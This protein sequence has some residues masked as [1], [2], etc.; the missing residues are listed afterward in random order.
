MR[1]SASRNATD[2]TRGSGSIGSGV[3][4]RRQVLTDVVV[5]LGFA[6]CVVVGTVTVQVLQAG[7]VRDV[8]AVAVVLIVLAALLAVGLRR[9]EPVWGLAGAVAVVG[10]YLLAGYPYGP[11]QLCMV[12]AM[13][14]VARQRPLRLSAIA[15]GVATVVASGTVAVRLLAGDVQSPALV[16]LAWTGWIVLP[17]SLGA[18][19]QMVAAARERARRELVATAAA[20]ERTRLAGE[21][22]DVAGHGFAVVAMQ[23]G[24]ALQ[25]FDESPDQVRRSLEAIRTTSAGSLAELRGMLDAFEQDTRG[26]AAVGTLVGEVRAAGLE[27][28]LELDIGGVTVPRQ[29][30]AVAFRVVQEALTNVV[31][32]AGVARAEVAIGHN[33]D[34]LVVRVVDRGSAV[35]APPGRGLSGMRERIEALGGRLEA[36]PRDGGGFAVLAHLP[37]GSPR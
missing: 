13:F 36:G 37:L 17:W 1:R 5:A 7:R 27:V 10:G 33:G 16:V 32:H 18:L 9:A 8:D 29:V 6:A 15:C 25:V 26:L 3:A 12:I 24:I 35:A 22:H 19:V 20:Q 30:D 4:S 2:Q 28:G 14:E 23:A 11:I 34:E 21:V 31:R